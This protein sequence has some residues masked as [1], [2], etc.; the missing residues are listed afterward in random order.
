[1]IRRQLDKNIP[2][3]DH[4]FRADAVINKTELI[5]FGDGLKMF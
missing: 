3:R 5:S 2:P 1:M 4:G